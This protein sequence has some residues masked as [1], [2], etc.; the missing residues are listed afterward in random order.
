MGYALLDY[1]FSER[2]LAP[3]SQE[4]LSESEKKTPNRRSVAKKKWWAEKKAK[5]AAEKALT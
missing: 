1:R 3:A 5:E 2:K 4:P